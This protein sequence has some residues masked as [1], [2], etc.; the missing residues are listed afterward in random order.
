MICKRTLPDEIFS[1]IWCLG[2]LQGPPSTILSCRHAFCFD[3]IRY[4]A[5][6]ALPHRLDRISCPSHN[7]KD[8]NFSP[9]LLPIRSGYRILSLDGGGV[10]GFAQLIILGHIEKECFDI[11]TT[12][13][14]DLIVGTSIGGQIALALSAPTSTPLTVAE[15]TKRFQ[16]L[17]KNAF[18]P[19][20]FSSLP[21]VSW[22]M[23]KTKYKATTL[24]RQ[25]KDIFGEE[26]QFR[27]PTISAQSLPNVAVT[28]TLRE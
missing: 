23:D 7:L 26:T 5:N 3:C 12:Q 9:R 27:V 6:P 15:A 21:F 25:L 1:F 19:K 8:Q 13:L 18:D 14:Y 16:E 17:I 10:K 11:P 4:L 24:E 22:A 28:V 20:P 2:C